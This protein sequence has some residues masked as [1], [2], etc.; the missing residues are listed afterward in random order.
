MSK[1]YKYKWQV[2]FISKIKW[3]FNYLT[4]RNIDKITTSILLICPSNRWT[5][6]QTIYKKKK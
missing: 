6:N 1:L 3:L 5:Y 4:N 2:I